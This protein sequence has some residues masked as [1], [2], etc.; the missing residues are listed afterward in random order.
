MNIQIDELKR[1]VSDWAKG[2]PY[3]MA[4]FLFGSY[5][6]GKQNPTDV[7]I[8][9]LFTE[10]ISATQIEFIIHDFV[11]TWENDLRRRTGLPISLQVYNPGYPGGLGQ[12]LKEGPR[13]LLCRSVARDIGE[14]CFQ[15]DLA[16][17]LK[18]E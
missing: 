15:K 5:L 18:N 13:L 1:I 14:E 16:A 12:Y 7:D 17:L 9:I 11:P 10:Y 4:V 6:K 2:I 8:A 3:S